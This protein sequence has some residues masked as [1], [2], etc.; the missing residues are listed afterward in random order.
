MMENIWLYE[1]LGESW[2][3][4][5]AKDKNEA[6]EK[7]KMRMKNMI[8]YMMKTGQLS[9]NQKKILEIGSQIRPMYWKCLGKRRK[10]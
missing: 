9:L 2:G 1:I 6:E 3:V 10:L 4:V 7:V 5:I 8:H